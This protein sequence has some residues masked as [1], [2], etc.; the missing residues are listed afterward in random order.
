M[1]LRVLNIPT[2]TKST[3]P[4]KTKSS[5]VINIASPFGP[6]SSSLFNNA[7]FAKRMGVTTVTLEAPQPN[8][9]DVALHAE[10]NKRAS[11]L[12]ERCKDKYAP[13]RPA[14]S[15]SNVVMPNPIVRME[16]CSVEKEIA[17]VLACWAVG[18]KRT[19]ATVTI[20]KSSPSNDA[21]SPNTR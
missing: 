16:L 6:A 11:E 14:V 4:K 8:I 10:P 18:E 17:N 20:V 19:T 12:C 1:N 3:V 9:A 7:G 13:S 2:E 21:T 15:A 5:H